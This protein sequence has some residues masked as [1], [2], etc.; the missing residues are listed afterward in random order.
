MTKFGRACLFILLPCFLPLRAQAQG[1]PFTL[2][3]VMSAAFPTDLTPAPAGGRVAWVFNAKGSRNVWIAEPSPSNASGF[4]SRQLTNYAGDNGQDVGE[5]QWTPDGRMIVY[6]RGGDFEFQDQAYPNP[7]AFPEGAEQDIWAV[8][9]SGGPPTKLAEGHS[10]AIS[11]KGNDVAYVYKDQIWLAKLDG[12]AKPEQLIH[13]IGKARQL[14]WSP[15][16]SAL[17][18]VSDRGNHRLIAV[19]DLGA[20]NLIF[21]DPSVDLDMDPV[22]SPDGKRIAFVRIP[23]SHQQIVFG[24]RRTGEPWSIRVADAA[25]GIGR[26]IW[27]AGPGQGSVFRGIAAKSDLFWAAGNLL[28]FPWEKDGWTHLYSVSAESGKT[29]LL[30]Q[31]NFIVEDVFLSPDRRDLIFNSNE[32]DIDRRHIWKGAVT[33]SQPTALT[34][35]DGIE[36]SPVIPGGSKTLFILRSGARWPARPA[37]LGAAGKIEDIARGAV[38]GDFPAKSLVVPRQVIILAADGIKIHGQLFLP[39]GA[40]DGTRHPAIV[41]FHGGSRR[42]MLLGWHYMG[43]YNNAYA[44]NQYLASRGYVVLSVNYRSGI[45]Y[46]LDFREALDYGATG[47]SEYNDVQGAGLYLRSRPDVD[48]KRIG[49][50]G[51]SYGGYLTAMALAR[52]SDLFAAGVDMHGVHDWNIEFPVW[53]TGYNPEKEKD[54]ARLAFDS[55]P[56]AYV[57][58]WRSPVLLIQ[59]DDDRNVPFEEMVRLVEALRKQ[60]VEFKQIVI[61]DEIH[62][63]LRHSSWLEAYQ[64]GSDFFDQH[65][66]R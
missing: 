5:I 27:K 55:S 32:N 4:A 50:W 47:A 53:I 30:T 35:G 14:Q 8:S 44:M 7:A 37:V 38:P 1:K 13:D 2:K 23:A 41:F 51:G 22:W 42:Q 29:R 20:K 25:T 48:P 43:Y 12:S 3:Q 19:Y 61:P 24:P 54:A 52:S 16:G 45:G 6:T 64:A 60:G 21:L 33:G 57:K 15:D 63:F 65:L 18:F 36:W 17:A 62:D 11:L 31:G 10:A 59:G 34:Q 56:L 9:I 66:K 58:T 28:V 40:E 26:Q 49:V 46:G 39:E